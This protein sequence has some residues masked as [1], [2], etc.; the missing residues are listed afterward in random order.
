MKDR[1][2]LID[3]NALVH[4]AYHALPSLTTKDGQPVGAIYGFFQIFLKAVGDLKPKY[5]VM[6]FDTPSPT[7]RHEIYTDYKAT[8]QKAPDE[9]YEQFPVIKDI[10][11]TLNLPIFEIPGFEADDIVGTLARQAEDQGL[12]TII[13]TGDLDEVQ[14]VTENTEVYTMRKG[15]T[16]TVIYHIEEVKNRFQMMPSQIVDYKALRGDASDNIPGVPGIGEKTATDL[17]VKFG[18]LDGIYKAVEGNSLEIKDR[19]KNTLSEYRE[20]AYLSQKL[21]QINTH[22]PLTLAIND[23]VL[24]NFDRNEVVQMFQKFEFRTLL[25]KIPQSFMEETKERTKES[26]F[27]NCHH[28][29]DFKALDE[30]IKRAEK[31]PVWIIDTETESL[32][33]FKPE[34]VGFSVAF[35]AKEAWF[36]RFNKDFPI[37]DVLAKIKPYL[38][39]PD[40][41]KVG[42][43]IRYDYFVF[44]G[45]G[46]ELAPLYFDTMLAAY[47]LAPGDRRYNLDDLSFM[48]FGY[49]KIHLLDLIGKGRD[50]IKVSEVPE[51]KIL[52]YACEDVIMTYKLYEKYKESL[53]K[54]TLSNIFE[55]IEMPLVPVLARMETNG[56]L[57]DSKIL[58][59]MSKDFDVKI[60]ELEK[61]IHAQAGQEFNINSP[62]QLKKILFEDLEVQKNVSND[63]WHGPKKVKTGGYSTA[64]SELTK[65]KN[66]HPIIGKISKYRELT[67]LKNTYIDTLPELLGEDGRIHTSY[68]QTGTA[69][70]RLSSYE[71]NLQNI[72]IRTEIGREIR[73]AFVAGKGNVLVSADY[74]QIELRLIAELAQDERMIKAFNEGAD[75]HTKTAAEIAGIDIRDVSYEQRRAAKAINFGVIYGIS[76]HGLTESLGI[77]N[78]EA[79]SYL[80]RYFENHPAVKEYMTNTV[81]LANELGHVD[82]IFGRK[83]FLPEIN[84]SNFMVR[85]GA[86][87]M[88]INF[89]AQGTAADIMKIRSLTPAR[90]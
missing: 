88:A 41:K 40:I 57:V 35:D 61:E 12:E 46:I 4:R 54:E 83:R 56:V 90:S 39:N 78:E 69:T 58:N 1:I 29:K 82:T 49:E 85:S 24:G 14:L 5:V 17:I 2:L 64:A 36:A 77:P 73:K 59:E 76:A 71:P 87:R 70:G 3:A 13:V 30:F 66:A 27:F 44:R 9:L 16:D 62:A 84:S 52:T 51:E 45:N 38:K 63:K 19:V 47:I 89:P 81:A 68:N 86:E 60:K 48:E 32:D 42:H 34:I 26:A 28:I 8:R 79:K 10:I 50:Q 75:I 33:R 22:V 6:A 74:S 53:K 72:P 15:F 65:L 21:A 31:E 37:K 18:S 7:F 67:K 25:S 23:S 11:G 55:G 20:Q 43:N 80:N